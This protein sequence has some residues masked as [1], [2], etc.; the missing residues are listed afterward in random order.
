MQDLTNQEFENGGFITE[1]EGS[2]YSRARTWAGVSK[3]DDKGLFTCEN[4][5]VW[6]EAAIHQKQHLPKEGDDE[7]RE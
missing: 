4:N 6:D 1:T 3:W 5:P 2:A 7:S